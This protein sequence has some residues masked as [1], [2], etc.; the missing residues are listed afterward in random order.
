MWR[1][2]FDDDS[3]DSGS[4]DG[5]GIN[6]HSGSE[7]DEVEVDFRSRDDVLYEDD[8]PSHERSSQQDEVARDDISSPRPLFKDEEAEAARRSE[9]L[10]YRSGLG[11]ELRTTAHGHDITCSTEPEPFWEIPEGMTLKGVIN[12]DKAKQTDHRQYKRRLV[13]EYRIGNGRGYSVKNKELHSSSEDTF[14]F[15]TPPLHFESRFESG[16]LASATQVAEHEYELKLQFDVNTRGNTQ[17]FYFSVENT[18]K[19]VPYV[20]R[21][22]NLTKPDSLYN[23]GMKPLIYSMKHEKKE[24]RRSGEDIC[25]YANDIKRGKNKHSD[26]YSAV[27][28]I[29]FEYEMDCVYV[30]YCYP[31]TYSKL[32]LYLLGLDSDPVKA[33]N[34]RRK[35]LCRSLAGNAVDLVTIT[36][37]AS[38]PVELSH[39]PIVV[40]S[41]RVHPGE[42]VASFMMKGC[43][44]FLTSENEEAAQ[45]RRMFIFKV[46]PMLNP[47]GVIN[48]NY[49]ANLAGKDLNRQYLKPH[50]LVEPPV[51]YMKQM[52]RR[53][54]A[55]AGGVELFCDFHGHSRKKNIFVYGCD[56][57]QNTV[58]PQCPMGHGPGLFIPSEEKLFP[59]L[60][61]KIS[62]DFQYN[63]CSFKISKSKKSTGRVVT[64]KEAGINRSYTLEASFLGSSTGHHYNVDQLERMGHDFCRGLL[65]HR[66]MIDQM[67]GVSRLP[68][69]SLPFVSKGARQPVCSNNTQAVAPGMAHC[70]VHGTVSQERTSQDQ[71]S[72]RA[73]GSPKTNA[74]QSP[75][76]PLQLSMLE[77]SAVEAKM[78]AISI[79]GDNGASISLDS[80]L[81]G[82]EDH[83]QAVANGNVTASESGGSDAEPSADELSEPELDVWAMN[84]GATNGAPSSEMVRD[85]PQRVGKS[86]S[87]MKSLFKAK[88][89]SKRTAE[90]HNSRRK[91]K[92]A[93]VSGKGSSHDSVTE[94]GEKNPRHKG[95]TSVGSDDA[96]SD[97]SVEDRESR[98][99]SCRSELQRQLAERVER[100][101]RADTEHERG[102]QL[103]SNKGLT[104]RLSED[105]ARITGMFKQALKQGKK[106]NTTQAARVRLREGRQKRERFEV[107]P[108]ATVTVAFGQRVVQFTNSS[109]DRQKD[110]PPRATTPVQ[111]VPGRR[112]RLLQADNEPRSR[113]SLAEASPAIQAEVR[114]ELAAL[115][116]SDESRPSSSPARVDSPSEA[117]EGIPSLERKASG[118]L[119]QKC[120]P[121][122]ASSIGMWIH[123]WVSR[124]SQTTPEHM[125]YSR[126]PPRSPTSNYVLEPAAMPLSPGSVKANSRRQRSSSDFQALLPADTKNSSPPHPEGDGPVTQK[127]EIFLKDSVASLDSR[128]SDPTDRQMRGQ[129]RLS[130]IYTD[131]GSLRTSPSSQEPSPGLR[132]E[133]TPALLLKGSA[134]CSPP[135][136]SPLSRTPSPT[137]IGTL[138][139]DRLVAIQRRVDQSE[140]LQDS[141][142]WLLP[143]ISARHSPSQRHGPESQGARAHIDRNPAKLGSNSLGSPGAAAHDRDRENT[144]NAYRH[145]HA[146]ASS[147]A[148]QLTTDPIELVRNGRRGM[149]PRRQGY[150]N[151]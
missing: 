142:Q 38:N 95:N 115:D 81:S 73:W 130:S 94:N 83:E 42:T 101:K 60:L 120:A 31:Y 103:K 108:G 100:K 92:H 91:A 135:A 119:E 29:T 50:Q 84:S 86:S 48:G 54:A 136:S 26:Y 126:S 20:F 56:P 41:A 107:P 113:S 15:P 143:D 133:T 9:A 93:G 23:Q 62:E 43:L 118:G 109:E 77:N 68:T 24:W 17:W 13:Y 105:G 150:L 27:F 47:D 59:A 40:L 71:N 22:V 122:P 138:S 148:T 88:K 85:S 30:A 78:S 52:L 7:D 66:K 123:E 90:K 57:R 129:Q 49:R 98:E 131:P 5:D 10:K 19:D 127:M 53:W 44:D 75:N 70:G 114:Q 144:S 111:P 12:A 2:S 11:R 117:P 14:K 99:G 124:Q 25:Y 76:T 87:L 97:P 69:G 102:K 132:I 89:P 64:W 39:R 18:Q 146:L 28:T 37:P 104:E 74:L 128:V 82:I 8:F 149:F 58:G 137:R 80:L 116:P 65:Q 147:L 141:L 134:A 1:N 121:A 34:I 125:A 63:A 35:L 106:S 140:T 55:T 112:R 72:S 61:D 45:L 33:K 110:Y 145:S 51:F 21:V 79:V 4:E 3:G 36:E 151:F 46:I 16:N 6:C 139:I 67:T 96:G 32:Q